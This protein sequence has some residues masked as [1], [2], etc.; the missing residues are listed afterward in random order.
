MIWQDIAISIISI[1]FGI[2]LVPQ[3][4]YGFRDKT[5][6]IKF[7]TSVPTTL[8]LY[9]LSVIYLTLSLYFSSATAFVTGTLWLVLVIQRMVYHKS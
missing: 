4:Y 8:G 7:L 6:P 9:G 5:G 3:V 1:I 2:S